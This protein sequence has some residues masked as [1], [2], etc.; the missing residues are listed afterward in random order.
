MASWNDGVDYCTWEGVTCDSSTGHIVGLDLS[1]D[2]K[3]SGT[4]ILYCCRQLHE[5]LQGDFISHLSYLQ[6]L[7]LANNCFNGSMIPSSF[8]RLTSLTYLNL[9]HY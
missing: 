4:P 7:N 1:C 3:L 9:S 8:A 5:Q 6:S 2:E